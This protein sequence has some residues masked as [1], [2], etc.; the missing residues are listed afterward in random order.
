MILKKYLDTCDDWVFKSR[1]QLKSE[2]CENLRV[3]Y[4]IS[5]FLLPTTNE[6]LQKEHLVRNV[7]IMILE[8]MFLN[9]TQKC[10]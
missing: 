9:I 6:I 2:I 7:M 5:R 4:C 1:H 3:D 8:K 10:K